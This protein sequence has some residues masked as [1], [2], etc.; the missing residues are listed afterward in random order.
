MPLRRSVLLQQMGIDQW[1][2]RRPQTL[3]GAAAIAVADNIKLL[4][5]SEHPPVVTPF[6][7][8]IYRALGISAQDCLSVN[9]EQL[10]RLTIP[11]PLA[12]WVLGENPPLDTQILT[13]LEQHNTLFTPLDRQ[14]LSHNPQAKRQLWQ[15]LQQF[16]LQEEKR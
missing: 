3:K 6:L 4:L 15:Q 12:V 5:V 1:V 8:D 16:H 9:R 2:L 11:Q 14:T 10:T 13:A 7:Q